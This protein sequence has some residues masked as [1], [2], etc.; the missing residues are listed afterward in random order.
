MEKKEFVLA[1]CPRC[2]TLLV[3]D[4]RYKTKT[5]PKCNSRIDVS[6]LVVLS[7]A[8]DSRE[9]RV[10]LSKAKLERAG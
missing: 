8:K 5:C 1:E 3:A 9:A 10:L 4:R 7:K 6:A 2:K